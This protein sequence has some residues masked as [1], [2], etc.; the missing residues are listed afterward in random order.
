MKKLLT[1]LLALLMVFGLAAC[2][3]AAEPEVEE[4]GIYGFAVDS[5]TDVLQSMIMQSGVGVWDN[6]SKSV[7]FDD[8]KVYEALDWYGKGV[9]EGVFL[10]NPS[11]SNYF[12]DDYNAKNIAMYVGSV[13]G[14]PYLKESWKTAPMP[15]TAGGTTWT[16]AWNRGVLVFDYGDEARIQAAAAFIEFFATP[17]QNTAWCI[18]CNY[19]TAL[20]STQDF[21]A[22]QEYLASSDP[23]VA[24]LNALDPASAGAFPAV[25]AI[26]P[27]RTALKNAMSDAAAGL[28]GEE[29]VKNAVEFVTNE[30]ASVAESPTEYTGTTNTGNTDSATVTIWHTY[31]DAQNDALNKA[32][33]EFNASQDKYT[34]L[35]ESQDRTG[36]DNTVYQAVMAGNG[37]DI[38]IDY[39]ST[40]ATYVVD[41]K[42]VD[43]SQF[44]SAD[45]VAQL[46]A[47]ALEEATSFT[48][49]GLHVFPIVFSGPVLFYNPDLLA[50]YEV[51]V[52]TTWAEVYEASVKIHEASKKAQ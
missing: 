13:A 30:L 14:A 20:K 35:V 44:L 16:P 47:G 51:E 22:Y 38:I 17:E 4:A 49:G 1:I 43:L 34:V 52:P 33:E 26:S 12:S 10:S 8:A 45:L 25:P 29:A 21:A 23:N 40:A 31:T 39:A 41:G 18:A 42:S 24:A 5:A 50:Q 27:I 28:S 2:N 7:L 48:D 36:F 3:K 19:M 32:A 46:N 37:P 9:Q 6:A 11:L 15:Q